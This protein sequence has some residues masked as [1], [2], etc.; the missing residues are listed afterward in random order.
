M[1]NVAASVVQCE[2]TNDII[3]SLSDFVAR[4]KIQ[5]SISAKVMPSLPSRSIMSK[6]D[7]EKKG[8]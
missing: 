4:G 8:M 1:S 6:K 7:S 2:R 3:L 5:R